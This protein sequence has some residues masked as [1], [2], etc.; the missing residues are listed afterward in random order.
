L[1]LQKCNLSSATGVARQRE[2]LGAKQ[3]DGGEANRYHDATI[4]HKFLRHQYLTLG[5]NT[6]IYLRAARKFANRK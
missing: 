1:S 4:L 5:A 3:K 2:L 6:N